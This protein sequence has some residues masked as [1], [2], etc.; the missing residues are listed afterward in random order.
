MP[1]NAIVYNP[2]PC[3]QKNTHQ[4][5]KESLFLK[6]AIIKLR[7]LKGVHILQNKLFNENYSIKHKFKEL[8]LVLISFSSYIKKE[9]IFLCNYSCS[10]SCEMRF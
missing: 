2:D 8:T 6:H 10:Y 9:P 4:V 5:R 3:N 1:G 7:K